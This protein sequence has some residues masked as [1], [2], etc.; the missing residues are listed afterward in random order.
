[1]GIERRP[2]L[3]DYWSSRRVFSQ[4]FAAK[5]MTRN[6]FVQILN[7]LHFV[8][9]SNAD[10]SDRLSKIDA[11]VKILKRAFAEVYKPGREVC[12][13]ES[14]IPFR[15]RVLFRQYLRGKRYKYGLKL[16]K[17]CSDDGYIVRFIV[18][19]SK[20]PS[21]T[22][23]AA[24]YVVT[25]LMEPYLDSEK[26]TLGRNVEKNRVGIPKDITSAKLQRGETTA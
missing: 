13:D 25:K 4:S 16:Y 26:N 5:Y 2:D 7:S 11:V 1:M 19:A 9:T 8:D 21:R 15:G 23:S 18:Y 6:R 24:E 3:K 10:K 14:M 17:L 22:G 12:I 20:E